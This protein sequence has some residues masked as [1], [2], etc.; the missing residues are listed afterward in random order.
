MRKSREHSHEMGIFSDMVTISANARYI[1]RKCTVCKAQEILPR[2]GKI[3]TG[4]DIKAEAFRDFERREF[5]KDLLQ[6]KDKKGNIDE[7]YD[8]AW[9]DPYKK[10]KIGSRTAAFV[11][12]DE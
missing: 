2:N 1:E 7:L 4:Y 9:G 6:P 10:S 8:H 5:A 12:K 11:I 3:Y